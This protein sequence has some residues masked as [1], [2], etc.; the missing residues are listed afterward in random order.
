MNNT[1]NGVRSSPSQIQHREADQDLL[2]VYLAGGFRSGWQDQVMAA[3]EGVRFVDPRQHHLED[4]KHYTQWDLDGVRQSDWV[5]AFFEATNPG[6]FSL[7]LEVGFAKA[8]EKRIIY[9]DQK[10]ANDPQVG[11]YL[12]M[13]RA[14]ADVVFP[15]LEEGIRFLQTLQP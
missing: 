14:C 13:V 2:T 1:L 6:G 8:L 15:S 9:I 10:S 12:G 4:E 11:R 5:F 3:I 7:A